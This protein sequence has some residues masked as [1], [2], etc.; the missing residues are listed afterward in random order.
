MSDLL[1]D[2]AETAD[3]LT[4]PRNHIE[5]IE[6][7]DHNRNRKRKR[8]ELKLPSLLAQL[9][10]AVVPG[11]SYA[12]EGPVTAA[13]FGSRPPARLDAIDRLLAIEAASARWCWSLR[14]TLRDEPARNIRALVGAAAVMDSDT[15]RTLLDDL[16]TWRTWAATVTG[17]QR[18]PDAPRAPCP[19][20][21]AYGTLRVRLDRSTACCLSCGAAWDQT[22]ITI[23]AELVRQYLTASQEAAKRARAEAVE[24]RRTNEGRVAA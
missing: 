2:I 11:E 6:A 9:A 4:E 13:A 21:E 1:L 15:M 16:R 14:L 18:P 8:R 22:N 10:Q 7:W 20:C 19:D 5:I 3:E 24:K 23:L 17:W 12:E